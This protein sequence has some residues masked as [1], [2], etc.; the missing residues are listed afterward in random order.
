MDVSGWGGDEDDEDSSSPPLFCARCYSLT[1]YGKVKSTVAESQLPEFDIGK[2]VGQKIR[3][4]HFR[5]SGK[6]EALQTAFARDLNT[7][8]GKRK[9]DWKNPI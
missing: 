4:R 2:K 9:R 1:H 3:L 6:W 7:D 5:R 8:A